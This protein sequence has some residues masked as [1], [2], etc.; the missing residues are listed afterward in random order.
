MSERMLNSNMAT[1]NIFSL[2]F[3]LIA[4]SNKLG[5]YKETLK[6]SAG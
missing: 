2:S 5:S 3:D 4:K 1:S 6:S